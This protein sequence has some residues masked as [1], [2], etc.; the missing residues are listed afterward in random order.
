[1]HCAANTVN[2]DESY[3]FDGKRRCL[4]ETVCLRQLII[5]YPAF[6]LLY[7]VNVKYLTYLNSVRVT[8]GDLLDY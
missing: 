6:V 5:H 3:C 8:N 7:D 1:M 2:V 4:H